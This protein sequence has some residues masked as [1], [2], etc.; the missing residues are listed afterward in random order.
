MHNGDPYNPIL[1]DVWSSGILLYS[2]VCGYLPF[3]EED[4]YENIR[5]IL[6][7]NYELPEED[8]SPEIID[9]I[10]HL[11]D[12]DP[13]TRYTLEEIK[14]HPWFNLISPNS[15]PGI[16]IGYHRIP[17]DENIIKQCE[18]FGYNREEV[19][20]S[21]EKNRYNKNSAMYY[22]LLKKAEIQGI[23]SIS[24]LYSEKYL[25]Y[26]NDKNNLLTEE[27]INKFKKEMEENEKENKGKDLKN[28]FENIK[29]ESLENLYSEKSLE[30]IKN[31]ESSSENENKKGKKELVFFSDDEQNDEND[32]NDDN[33]LEEIGKKEI[34][35]DNSDQEINNNSFLDIENKNELNSEKLNIKEEDD[36]LKNISIE[37][38]ENNQ[39]DKMENNN[40]IK[41]NN[42]VGNDNKEKIS[43]KNSEKKLEIKEEN[44]EKKNKMKKLVKIKSCRI[45]RN[46]SNNNI[47][48]EKFSNKLMRYHS[49]DLESKIYEILN[50]Q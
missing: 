30:E 8:L 44:E 32:I 14:K 11:L 16:I 2:M 19:I 27:E 49:F 25:E 10:K 43:E 1:S 35:K 5:N 46:K 41:D 31:N 22:I 15:R 18:S 3:S 9:L 7:G 13:K 20:E 28:E 12:I 21:V 38:T 50:Y 36:S 34:S 23:E 40:K 4:E 47:Q 37:I 26:I 24:D 17:I 6:K 39:N 45:T 29:D 42:I 48:N 33:E